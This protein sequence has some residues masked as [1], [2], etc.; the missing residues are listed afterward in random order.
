MTLPQMLRTG[1]WRSAADDD[2]VAQD[3]RKDCARAAAVALAD[4]S[5]GNASYDINGPQALTMIKIVG[6]V[7]EVTGKPIRVIS[8]TSEQ[9]SA[10]MATAGVPG[11]LISLLGAFHLNTKMG[12]QLAGTASSMLARAWLRLGALGA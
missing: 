1:Q 5:K 12:T 4:D 7:R 8:Q 11:F 6:F 3:S 2:A 10:S 9:L